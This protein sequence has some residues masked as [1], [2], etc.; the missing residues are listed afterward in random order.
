MKLSK[1]I[2]EANRID[3]LMEGVSALEDHSSHS[4]ADARAVLLEIAMTAARKAGYTLR[5][6]DGL[7]LTQEEIDKREPAACS[8]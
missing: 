3:A 2:G 4:I 5:F 6:E 7:A 8:E 1:C